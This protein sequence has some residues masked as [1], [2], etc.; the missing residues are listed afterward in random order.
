LDKEPEAELHYLG[1]RD[2]FSEILSEKGVRVHSVPSSK[3]RRYAAGIL[4]NIIDVP[5]FGSAVLLSLFKLYWLMP[6][7]VFSKGGPGAFAVVLAAR[8]YGIPVVVH[9]SDSVPGLTNLFSGKFAKWVAVSWQSAQKYF[10]TDRAVWV[11]QPIRKE[12]TKDKPI[13]ELA[14]RELNFDSQKPLILVLGSSQGSTRINEFILV[15][16]KEILKVGQVLHQTGRSNFLSAKKVAEI[17]L[18]DL[19][20]DLARETRY[21]PV[22][23]L[24]EEMGHA[25]AA[26]DVVVSRASSTIFEIAAFGKPAIL[27]PLRESA[28]DHQ[29]RNGYEFEKTGGGVVI[30]EPN[31]VPAIFIGKLRDILLNQEAKQKASA[32]SAAFFRPDGAKDVAELVLGS[33]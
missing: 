27:I 26:A 9:E 1:P 18:K 28:N 32:A 21:V 11:G 17:I 5:R 4:E 6:D 19:P 14:K 30:E 23:F 3:L 7:A 29:R 33:I 20:P 24:K 22:P 13:Q 10:R 12:L 2:E 25:L 15:N 16:L 8:F 31:L